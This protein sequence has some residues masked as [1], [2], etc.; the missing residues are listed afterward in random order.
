MSS[1]PKIE[2]SELITKYELHP[3]L[4]DIFVEGEF[5][6]DFLYYYFESNDKNIDVTILPID[7][8]QIESESGNS[9]KE[10]IISLATLI[11]RELKGAVINSVFI[12]D[13]DCDRLIN[14]IR[15]S[16][17]LYYTDFTCMEMYFYNASTLRKFLTFTCNLRKKDQ[18][19]FVRLAEA[20]L[21]SLFAARTVNDI[22]SLNV[23]TP[24][25]SAGLQ[26]KGDFNTFSQEKYLT[27]LLSLVSPINIRNQVEL[28]FKNVYGSL[29]SDL[30]HKAHG[31][32]FIFLL[33][34][35]LWKHRSLKLINKGE[36]IVRFGGRIL[37]TALNLAELS[38]S[39][40]FRRL[41]TKLL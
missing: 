25:F 2:L 6:R 27:N 10:A 24:G 20:I 16:K 3:E 31:H 19:D 7:F 21:P 14:R 37:G 32:D 8:I 18:E 4:M 22:F 28:K 5:D 39:V 17:Y 11:E 30:R 26:S 13:A 9:N 36:D 33:F 29:P 1:P 40:L 15:S 34:E 38:E 35:F 41:E 23:S 12:V